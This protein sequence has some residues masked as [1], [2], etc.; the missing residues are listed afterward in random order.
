MACLLFYATLVCHTQQQ[1]GARKCCTMRHRILWKSSCVYQQQRFLCL[2]LRK[3]RGDTWMSSCWKAGIMW[4]SWCFFFPCSSCPLSAVNP[5]GADS[6][7]CRRCHHVLFPLIFFLLFNADSGVRRA[8]GSHHFLPGSPELPPRQAAGDARDE[9]PFSCVH[10]EET[11]CTKQT[12]QRCRSGSETLVPIS[13][14]YHQ[15]Q[16]L[17]T[18]VT[19]AVL[20][21]LLLL[22]WNLASKYFNLTVFRVLN[23]KIHIV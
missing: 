18:G 17:E 12:R 10:P 14:V 9:L 23:E 13:V 19:H 3:K 16:N 7:R 8:P 6:E 1:P 22:T 15:L 2:R 21:V 4:S 20:K 5:P 11:D